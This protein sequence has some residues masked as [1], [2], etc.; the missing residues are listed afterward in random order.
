MTKEKAPRVPK[1]KISREEL[2]WLER[3]NQAYTENIEEGRRG[4]L[5]EIGKKYLVHDTDVWTTLREDY[6]KAIENLKGLTSEMF[7]DGGCVISATIS[8]K[9]GDVEVR[10]TR[11]MERFEATLIGTVDGEGT[12]E[13][14]SE[15]KAR[16][17]FNKLLAAENQRDTVNADA[18]DKTRDALIER[19][20]INNV[21]LSTRLGHL[22]S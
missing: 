16:V 20:L 11:A 4:A 13:T 9:H 17:L 8:S 3:L 12:S 10:V 2:I 14:L 6:K 15:A 1:P 7:E 5:A 18:E 22:F 21:P 19:G